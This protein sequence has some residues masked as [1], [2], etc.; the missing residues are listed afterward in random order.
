M[1]IFSLVSLQ[2][3]SS[4]QNSNQS[5]KPSIDLPDVLLGSFIDDYGSLYT[6]SKSEWHHGSSNSYRLISFDHDGQFIIAQNA[7][8][9]L[10]DQGLYSRI[11]I[12][13]FDNMEPWRWGYCL[14][15]YNSMT[16]QEALDVTPADRSNPRQ[17]CN[18]FPFTRMKED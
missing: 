2:F 1:I 16:I 15:S 10:S 3:V 9:N 13:F 6:I 14:T 8:T 12:M 7:E 18:G 11:D 5:P 17:G 4:C